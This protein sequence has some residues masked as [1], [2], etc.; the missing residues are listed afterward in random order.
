MLTG[1]GRTVLAP[2]SPVRVTD[3]VSQDYRLVWPLPI[4]TT[5]RVTSRFGR[6]TDPVS[7]RQS[8]H[9]GIDLDGETGNPIYAA[10]EGKVVF[11]GVRSG[12]GQLLIIDH[13][14]GLN[15]YYG[16]CLR[17][18]KNRGE[19]VDRGMIVALIGSSGRTT[20]SHLHFETRKH[21]RP[22]DPSLLLPKLKKL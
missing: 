1:C 16:H 20:G 11:S 2:G 14:R 7:G 21:G 9:G 17:L 15:T 8:F 12:Y 4:S 22:F 5:A 6:R 19:R 10:G 18:L 13:G 3:F